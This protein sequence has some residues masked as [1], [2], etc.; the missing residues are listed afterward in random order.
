MSRIKNLCKK[1]QEFDRSIGAVLIVNSPD[2]NFFYLTKLE[3]GVFNNCFTILFNDGESETYVSILEYEMAKKQNKD[4][5]LI[6]KRPDQIILELLRGVKHVGIISD[7]IPYKY[8]SLLE[9]KRIKVHDVS[10]VF[11]ES[12]LIKDKDEIVKMKTAARITSQI[13][14]K[15]SRMK[16]AGESDFAA[17]IGYLVRKNGCEDAFESICA[18]DKNASY[19]HYATRNAGVKN[20]VLLDFGARFKKYC[21]DLTRCV[22]RRET[23][24]IRKASD[25]VFKAYN[26]AMEKVEQ[27]ASGIEIHMAADKALEGKLIHS[28]GHF[29]GLEIHE[30]SLSRFDKPIKPGMI[31]TIEPGYY[32]S[33]KVGIRF[34]D[35]ILVTKN[36][37]KILTKKF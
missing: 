14:Q 12:R 22:V 7:K 21:A 1:L 37:Y 35:D 29:L 10:S 26:A 20:M 4:V 5:K 2:E 36:G 15:V 34:E 11:E 16:L 32:Q 30:G 25:L 17:E 24:Q 18:A 31:F 3:H 33:G 27:K 19:P 6:D 8:V 23:P 13:F 28:I 9:S